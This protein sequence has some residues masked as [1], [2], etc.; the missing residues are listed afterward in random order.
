MTRITLLFI[1]LLTTSILH[2]QSSYAD[3]SETARVTAPVKFMYD[4]ERGDESGIYNGILYYSYSSLIEGV[5]FYRTGEWHKGTVLFDEI[6]YKDIFM[7][8]E[9]VSDQLIVAKDTSTGIYISLYSPRVKEFSYS[10]MQFLRL[11]KKDAS[12]APETGFYHILV[13]GKLTALRRSVKVIEEKLEANKVDRWFEEKTKYYMLKDG[14]YHH[15]NN[16]KDILSVCK[17]H[18]KE[19][20][21]FLSKKKLKYRQNPETMIVLVAGFYNQ[22]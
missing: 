13:S 20:Q 9:L 4:S 1:S 17:D 8:Y 14:I 16:K 11:N 3:T 15:V 18:K 5:P 21:Q 19:V 10:G 22:L 7:R 6:W 12:P 2:G